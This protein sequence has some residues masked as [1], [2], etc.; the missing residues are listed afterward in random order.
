[1]LKANHHH[2]VYTLTTGLTQ[3][4]TSIRLYPSPTH[5][6]LQITSQLPLFLLYRVWSS[7]VIVHEKSVFFL[8]KIILTTTLN[9][10]LHQ[11]E[12]NLV[13]TVH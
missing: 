1:M 11:W 10:R 9:L 13:T 3:P 5:S 2:R 6:F 8:E 4:P 7:I 12:V